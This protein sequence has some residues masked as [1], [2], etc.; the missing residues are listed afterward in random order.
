VTLELV[1]KI[2]ILAKNNEKILV[3]KTLNNIIYRMQRQEAM[4]SRIRRRNLLKEYKEDINQSNHR[5]I[6]IINRKK[7]TYQK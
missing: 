7:K 3:I 2:N 1:E 6:I 5:N 4:G